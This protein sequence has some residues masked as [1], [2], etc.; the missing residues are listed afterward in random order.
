VKEQAERIELIE[1]ARR[2]SDA[3]IATLLP[4]YADDP[5][6]SGALRLARAERR[7]DR[8]LRDVFA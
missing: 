4:K 7:E 5:Y 2:C 1:K 3:Q 8:K 6:V